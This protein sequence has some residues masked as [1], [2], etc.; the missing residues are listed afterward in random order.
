[1][2]S[3]VNVF[4]FPFH[5]PCDVGDNKM[6]MASKPGK[7]HEENAFLFSGNKMKMASKPGKKHEEN[8]LL[9]GGNKMKMASKPGKMH[10]ENALF[11]DNKMEMA[12]L[13]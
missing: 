5:S 12:A 3:K 8:A 4:P 10:E 11:D 1:M 9:F 6:Q 13:S 7:K 2:F